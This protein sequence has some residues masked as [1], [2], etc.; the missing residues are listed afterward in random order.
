MRTKRAVWAGLLAVTFLAATAGAEEWSF[1][2]VKRIEIDGV[3]GDVSVRPAPGKDVVVRLESRVEPADAFEPRV[4]QSGSTVRIDEKWRGH[5]SR[6]HVGWTILVPPKTKDLR[7]EMDTASGD[8]EAEGIEARIDLDTASGDVELTDVHLAPS[9]DLSTASGDYKVRGTTLG[10]NC[11]LSTASG[12]LELDRV[13]LEEGCEISTA[14]GDVDA[15]DC[16]GSM[17]LSS[18]S[19]DVSI[20]NCDLV[21]RGKFTSASGDVELKMDKLPKDELYASSASG[22]V[23]LNVKDFGSNFK[24]TLIKREDRGR[25][26]CPFEFTSERTFENHYIYEEKTVERGKG[27]PEITL[28]TA[29]GSVVVRD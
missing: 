13:I 15:L 21:G 6:G 27:G 25:I 9:S 14:S 2:G 29:S 8:F 17:E 20:E 19:G 4:E 18:A 3:S 26:V 28:R 16:K 23:Q 1:S 11:E 12:D 7:L 24:L 22:D 5:N 10:E